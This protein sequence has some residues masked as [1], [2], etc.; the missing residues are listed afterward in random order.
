MISSGHYYSEAFGIILIALILTANR[1]SWIKKT[2]T[3]KDQ[4]A[5]SNEN[6][7]KKIEE[8]AAKSKFIATLTHEMRNFVAG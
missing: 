2:R 8:Y 7:S 3:Y 5:A 4:M 1:L 6:L